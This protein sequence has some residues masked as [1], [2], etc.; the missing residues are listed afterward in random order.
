L[1]LQIWLEAQLASALAIFLV[2]PLGLE[3]VA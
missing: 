3:L 1:Q 2:A